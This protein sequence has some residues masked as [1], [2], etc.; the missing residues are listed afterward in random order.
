MCAVSIGFEDMG[1]FCFHILPLR[2]IEKTGAYS[3]SCQILR[4]GIGEVYVTTWQ[5][6]CVYLVVQSRKERTG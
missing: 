5:K 6:V 1:T 2:R 4:F 3:C